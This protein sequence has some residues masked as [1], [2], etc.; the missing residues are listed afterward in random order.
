LNSLLLICRYTPAEK[1]QGDRSQT[2]SSTEQQHRENHNRK[3]IPSGTL[4]PLTG[5]RPQNFKIYAELNPTLTS[6]FM[7]F[8]GHEDGSPVMFKLRLKSEEDAQELKKAMDR[9]ITSVKAS[10]E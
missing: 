7:S 5:F 9:E 4:N 10:S 6:K 8:V 2:C 3:S 1:T